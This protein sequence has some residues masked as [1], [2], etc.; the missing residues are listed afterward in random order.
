MKKQSFYIGLILLLSGIGIGY[1]I[2]PKPVT[3]TTKHINNDITTHETTTTTK[4]KKGTVKTVVVRD[5][6]DRTKIE[7]KYVF[8]PRHS[9]LNVSGLVG[10]NPNVGIKIPIYGISV[11]KEVFG[12]FTVGA[13]GLTN[14]TLGL[15]IGINF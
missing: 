13:F 6:V 8:M 4:N 9:V 10:V 5:I 15:S 1:Y 11:S 2:R 12:P 3:E 7:E 14:G